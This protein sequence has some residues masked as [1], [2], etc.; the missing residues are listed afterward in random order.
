MYRGHGLHAPRRPASPRDFCEILF[1]VVLIFL[2][3]QQ[4]HRRRKAMPMSSELDLLRRSRKRK[5][6]S[7]NLVAHMQKYRATKSDQQACEPH[8]APRLPKTF[9]GCCLVLF[10][11]RQQNHRRR[12]A[13]D[14]RAAT[15]NERM[16]LKAFKSDAAISVS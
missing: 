12:I 7:S 16:K 4:I 15:E 14:L 3:H 1:C 8:G 5:N 13:P 11:W 10:L 6:E 2:W 9:A